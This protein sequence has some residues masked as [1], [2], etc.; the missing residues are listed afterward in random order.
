VARRPG[1]GVLS[2]VQRGAVVEMTDS[3]VTSRPG[4]RLVEGLDLVAR[5]IHP[6]IFR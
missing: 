6:E 4:P 5:A 3:D 1:W 2:A